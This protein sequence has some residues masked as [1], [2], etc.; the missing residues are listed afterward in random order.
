MTSIEILDERV[1]FVRPND[2]RLSIPWNDDEAGHERAEDGSIYMVVG[3]NV[4][5]VVPGLSTQPTTGYGS[6]VNANG[7]FWVG[8]ML[9]QDNLFRS[10]LWLV[11]VG[12]VAVSRFRPP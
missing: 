8:S 10:S 9:K 2:P 1:I 6:P 7:I 5:S 4:S 12:G 3:K 11:G